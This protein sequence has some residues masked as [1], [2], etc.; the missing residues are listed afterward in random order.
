MA[1]ELNEGPFKRR[2]RGSPFAVRS[3]ARR[4]QLD[5]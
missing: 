4:G 2:K 1:H 5:L 3:D